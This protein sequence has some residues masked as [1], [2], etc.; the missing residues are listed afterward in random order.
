MQYILLIFANICNIYE[1]FQG[2]EA[3][4]SNGLPQLGNPRSSAPLQTGRAT[5]PPLAASPLRIK[6]RQFLQNFFHYF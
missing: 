3:S 1:F 4:I 5:A 6:D 2:V